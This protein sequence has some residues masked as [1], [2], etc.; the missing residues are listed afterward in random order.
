MYSKDAAVD[1]SFKN[2]QN[3]IPSLKKN[4]EEKFVGGF[5][6][7]SPPRAALFGNTIIFGKNQGCCSTNVCNNCPSINSKITCGQNS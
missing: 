5:I 6:A 3:I 4:A 1:N 7:V 2:L